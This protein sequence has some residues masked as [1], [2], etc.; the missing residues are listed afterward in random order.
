M[1]NRV[2]LSADR[3]NIDQCI[4]LAAEHNLGL[5]VMAFAYPDVLDGP[6]ESVLVTYQRKLR[7]LPG[8]ITLHGPFMDMAS[9]SPD[10]RINALC[11]ERYQHAIQIAAELNARLVVFHA[12]FI[13]S[14]HN[15][16][17][18]RG[19]HERNVPFW[20]AL[21]EY[22]ATHQTTIALENMWEFEPGILGDL[23]RAVDHPRLRACL[24]VGHAHLFSD[25]TFALDDWLETLKPWLIHLHMNNNNGVIDEHY[26]FAWNDGVLNYDHILPRI[27]LLPAPLNAVLEMYSV[28]DMRESLRWFDLLAH[29][30]VQKQTSA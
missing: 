24:D 12:N 28:D 27:N 17:Y 16:P 29:I 20:A 3:N 30:P 14:L 1:I 4:D 26:G 10:G 7:S 23:L 8:P 2:L 6:W 22:A 9:G 19:W 18:R 11:F 25:Q 21:A 15:I 5:E 13:G